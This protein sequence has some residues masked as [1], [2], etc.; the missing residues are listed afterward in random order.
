M[1]HPRGCGGTA[2]SIN[3]IALDL[4]PSPRMRGN[5]REAQQFL[6][7][8]GAIPADAGEPPIRPTASYDEWGH[9]R[10][11]GGTGFGHGPVRQVEGPSPRMRGNR[12]CVRDGQESHG[13]IPADAGEPHAG[14]RGRR[15]GRGHPRGCGGTRFRLMTIRCIGGPSPRM[16]GNRG[17]RHRC[18]RGCGAIPADAG[19]PWMRGTFSNTIR[20]HPRG[21]GGTSGF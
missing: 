5:L 2:I 16:R 6:K 8:L 10:G 12:L 9:P 15:C 18:M 1:G 11:C 7:L 21:C 13:A 14:A 20:G 17:R 19:E 4:G 3:E